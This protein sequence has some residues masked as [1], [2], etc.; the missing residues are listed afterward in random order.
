MFRL[1]LIVILAILASPSFAQGDSPESFDRGYIV[2]AQSKPSAPKQP[3][4]S[5][6]I[7]TKSKS[8]VTQTSKS[9]EKWDGWKEFIKSHKRFLATDI[10]TKVQKKQSTTRRTRKPTPQKPIKQV[11]PDRSYDGN[12]H[13]PDRDQASYNGRRVKI[14][15]PVTHGTI[16]VTEPNYP[17]DTDDWFE[18]V[19]TVLQSKEGNHIKANRPSSLN[20][21]PIF[22]QLEGT[23][24]RAYDDTIRS[25]SENSLRRAALPLAIVRVKLCEQGRLEKLLPL[26]N[27]MNDYSLTPDDVGTTADQLSKW[28]RAYKRNQHKFEVAEVR[29]LVRDM[30][31]GR[32]NHTDFARYL[33]LTHETKKVT[34]D[35]AG[36]TKAQDA[37]LSRKYVIFTLK[38]HL[39][40]MQEGKMNRL[41][42]GFKNEV[43]SLHITSSELGL[44]QQQL[45][46][47]LVPPSQ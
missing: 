16:R 45:D 38:Q 32:F 7:D 12:I 29:E 8:N 23:R 4:L 21:P 5:R 44:T 33:H 14:I 3:K 18:L 35:E 24:R 2:I 11:V 36:L 26:T 10:K 19:G 30:Q 9:A 1:C 15:T 6:A 41:P 42:S 13:L 43:R 40:L 17:L 39:V 28:R 20:R 46:A 27:L 47:I 34:L 37:D 31:Q 22:K 25:E